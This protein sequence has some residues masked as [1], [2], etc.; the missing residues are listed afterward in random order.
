MTY[1]PPREGLSWIQR[2]WYWIWLDWHGYCPK[3]RVTRSHKYLGK[4]SSLVYCQECVNE[5]A[6]KRDRKS[7]RIRSRA[8]EIINR[9][10]EPKKA[11]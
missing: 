7:E 5:K 6:E 3:H 8:L 9:L 10:N 1:P 2:V 4:G 11:W